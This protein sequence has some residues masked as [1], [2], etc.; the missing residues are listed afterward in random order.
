M[1]L[2]REIRIQLLRP[3][4]WPKTHPFCKPNECLWV[5]VY[6]HFQNDTDTTVTII[7]YIEAISINSFSDN[8]R[9]SLL[10]NSVCLKLFK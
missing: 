6:L 4:I 5:F 3:N 8:F 9:L 2:K 10:T 7:Q 1:C